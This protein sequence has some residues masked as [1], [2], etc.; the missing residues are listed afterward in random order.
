MA[1]PALK[2]LAALPWSAILKQ[3]PA[4]LAVAKGLQAGLG[5]APPPLKPDA[6]IATLRERIVGLEAVQQEHARVISGLA[7]HVAGLTSALEAAQGLNR[8]AMLIGAA[9][10]VLALAACLLAW[11]L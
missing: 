1:R 8:R 5:G 3:A 7:E 2:V 6:D 11:L 10:L 4:F 9:G